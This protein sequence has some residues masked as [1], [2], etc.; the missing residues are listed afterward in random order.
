MKTNKKLSEEKLKH[1]SLFL[2]LHAWNELGILPINK[3]VITEKGINQHCTALFINEVFSGWLYS[4]SRNDLFQSVY[5]P[6]WF[7]GKK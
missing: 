3:P 4:Y 7:T 6:Y 5:I 2:Q 1:Y